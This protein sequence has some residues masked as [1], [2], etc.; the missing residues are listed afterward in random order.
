[1]T[2][3]AVCTRWRPENPNDSPC[4]DF[5]VTLTS[6]D[7][8]EGHWICQTGGH[9][10]ADV[11]LHSR[12]DDCWDHIREQ[13]CDA[14]YKNCNYCDRWTRDA[15]DHLRTSEVCFVYHNDQW[16]SWSD[17]LDDYNDQADWDVWLGICRDW[18]VEP[19]NPR[20]ADVPIEP[21]V[22]PPFQRSTAPTTF[23]SAWTS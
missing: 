5:E 10:R 3:Y 17:L 14:G 2:T 16:N 12:S 22:P 11:T 15:A 6:N 13:W 9:R 18:G 1:M 19:R 21:Y 23:R 7:A 8:S 4:Q 20:P